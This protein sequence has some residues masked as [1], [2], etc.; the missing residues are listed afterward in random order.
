[1]ADAYITATGTENVS[2]RKVAQ[3]FDVPYQTLR[4]RMAGSVDS[5]CIQMGRSPVL[6]LKEV[7]HLKEMVLVGY[8]YTRQEVVDLAS[9]YA[10][11]LDIRKLDNPFSSRWFYSFL[12]RW[13][14]L[15][16]IKPRAL[17]IARVKG[18]N[19]MCVDK[20]FGELRASRM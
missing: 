13:P 11:D 9:D 3:R 7:S 15:R 1:M 5:E 19:K 12:K 18:S 16:V 14:D 4:D 8:G 6:S 17:E 20:Y 10:V 2:I